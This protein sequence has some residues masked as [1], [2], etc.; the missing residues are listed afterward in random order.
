MKTQISITVKN[1]FF[2]NKIFTLSYFIQIFKKSR[3]HVFIDGQEHVLKASK[4]PYVFDLEPG[5][6]EIRFKDHL[7]SAKRRYWKLIFGFFGF[8]KGLA[9]GDG[10]DAIDE[11]SVGAQRGTISDKEHV[12]EVEFNEGDILNV[13]CKSGFLG[14]V[15]VKQI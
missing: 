2:L 14:K 1:E 11:A 6:H 5:K 12:M 3:I 7:E 10:V 9:F 4:T 13:Q 15:K 8:I